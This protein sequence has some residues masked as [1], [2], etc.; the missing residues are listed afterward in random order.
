MDDL[1]LSVLLGVQVELNIT[2][3]RSEDKAMAY[4]FVTN[5]IVFLSTS[6]KVG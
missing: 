3:C 5:A 4:T 2:L 6:A 1:H